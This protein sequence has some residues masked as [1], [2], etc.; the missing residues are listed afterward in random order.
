MEQT[1]RIEDREFRLRVHSRELQ[2]YEQLADAVS[3]GETGERG[4]LAREIAA[5]FRERWRRAQEMSAVSRAGHVTAA[6][7]SDKPPP[8]PHGTFP[9]RPL[10]VVISVLTIIASWSWFQLWGLVPIVVILVAALFSEAIRARRIPRSGRCLF[11][12][13]DLRGL[14]EPIPESLSG[15]SLGPRCAECGGP[16]P[17]VPPP[18]D[19][20]NIEAGLV[21]PPGGGE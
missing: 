21:R 5:D 1:P 4:A 12:G 8:Q 11:C 10:T 19:P 13:Y 2:R 18:V 9:I 20:A 6:L 15:V 16:W 14:P 17:Q 7:L 3:S